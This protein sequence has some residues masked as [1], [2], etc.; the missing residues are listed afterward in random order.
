MQSREEKIAELRRRDKIAKLRAR[1]AERAQK[2]AY[3]TP[4]YLAA[5]GEAT[6]LAEAKYEDDNSLMTQGKNALNAALTGAS[7]ANP[8]MPLLNR[9]INAGEQL[10]QTGGIDREKM[11]SYLKSQREQDEGVMQKSPLA[12]RIG[13]GTMM[14]GQMLAGLAAPA[15][16]IPLA[17]AS[18]Y[19]QGGTS[20]DEPWDGDKAR[21]GGLWGLGFSAIPQAAQFAQKAAGAAGKG[22]ARVMAGIKGSDIE[23]YRANAAAVNAIDTEPAGREYG[24]AIASMK[25]KAQKGQDELSSNLNEMRYDYGRE[26]DQRKAAL[27]KDQYQEGKAFQD[28]QNTDLTRAKDQE[29]LGIEESRLQSQKSQ[30]EGLAQA[31]TLQRDLADAISTAYKG[32][33]K[34]IGESNA[35]VLALL[36]QADPKAQISITAIKGAVTKALKKEKI[37]NTITDAPHLDALKEFQGYL[38]EIGQK[39]VPVREAKRLI[40]T[41]DSKLEKAYTTA[42]QGGYVGRGNAEAM[43]VRKSINR[44]L[45]NKVPGYK[46]KMKPLADQTRAK[47]GFEDEFGSSGD[48]IFSALKTLTGKGKENRMGTLETFERQFGGDSAPVLSEID[49]LRGR[50]YGQIAEEGKKRVQG[51]RRLVEEEAGADKRMFE[52][53]KQGQ[54]AEEGARFKGAEED[55]SRLKEFFADQQDQI[56]AQKKATAGMSEKTASGDL[57]RVGRFPEKNYALG[58]QMR[59]LAKAEGKDPEYYVQMAKNLATKDKFRGEFIRGSRGPNTGAMGLMGMGKAL[60]VSME[61]LPILGSI[62]A[63]GGALTDIFGPKAVKFAIDAVDG[64]NGQM[65]LKGYKEAAARGSEALRIYH[66]ELMRRKNQGGGD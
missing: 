13:Y 63:F 45:G 58:D 7:K 56:N 52:D 6:K 39:S 47:V 57:Q 42:G 33:G 14:G 65:I 36:D 53:F 11:K 31:E 25:D 62:G 35:E 18:S 44:M 27:A 34:K 4:E 22:Y 55:R 29:R 43:S 8:V 26:I 15:V 41:F 49:S 48:D 28:R 3:E 12:A 38:E 20:T 32:S 37:G 61:K 1:D 64:E 59:E 66:N 51:A 50:D 24:G 23:D 10:G 21:E 30:Q 46:Q 16:S 2:P 17:V 40:Q 5:E 9:G 60:G 19:A 54:T